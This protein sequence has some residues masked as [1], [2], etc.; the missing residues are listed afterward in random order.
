MAWRHY[1]RS[2]GPGTVR[3]M[4]RQIVDVRDLSFNYGEYRA[5][6]GV[7]F[8]VEPGQVFG[9]LGTNGA[10]KTTTLE[11]IQGFR[12]GA[13][14][15]VRVHGVDPRVSPGV[16][17]ADTGVVLQ[18]AGHYPEL[19]V[20]QTVAMWAAIS[21]RPDSVDG[22][23]RRVGIDHRA[24]NAVSTLSGGERRRLDLALAMWG[25]PALVILDEPTTGL[26]PESRRT[27]WGVVRD[28]RDRGAA[29]VLTTHYLE[30]AEALA[31]T[32]AIMH[33]GA[34]AAAGTVAEVVATRPSRIVVETP[35]SCP[36][37]WP[38]SPPPGVRC[39]WGARRGRRVLTVVGGEQ[40][41][42]LAWLLDTAAR[43]DVALGPLRATPA[44]LDE[45]FLAIAE[46]DETG[47]ESPA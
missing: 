29:I 18:E 14:G 40:Q 33:R 23:L 3:T 46:S 26:D 7:S 37:E 39:E 19:S 11:L 32:V 27:R 42:T 15:H 2:V 5:V 6:D 10:G 47:Q 28:L 44:S 1:W 22:V 45:V 25:S 9:L 12:R 24:P 34:V 4:R 35:T 38:H 17:R 13:G 30:E 31:D 8:S 36:P 43:H 21:S 16:V 20:R 41:R